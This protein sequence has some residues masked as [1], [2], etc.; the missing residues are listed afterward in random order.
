MILFILILQKKTGSQNWITKRL[1]THVWVGKS[2]NFLI[3]SSFNLFEGVVSNGYL[4]NV[5]S[6]RF[7]FNTLLTFV[8]VGKCI[9]CEVKNNDFFLWHYS[10]GKLRNPKDLITIKQTVLITPIIRVGMGA[11]EVRPQNSP[12]N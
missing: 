5:I 4:E 12:K 11:E 9:H 8:S 10:S 6:K 1:F 7:Y 2:E 3:I